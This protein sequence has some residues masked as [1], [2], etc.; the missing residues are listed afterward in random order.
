MSMIVETIEILD[1]K[2]DQIIK[3]DSLIMYYFSFSNSRQTL[4]ITSDIQQIF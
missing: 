4:N 2:N 1:S 3:L